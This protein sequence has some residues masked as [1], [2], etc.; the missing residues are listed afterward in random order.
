M[1]YCW[2]WVLWITRL[3]NWSLWS[4]KFGTLKVE[5]V[6]TLAHPMVMMLWWWWS[7][8]YP[9]VLM[10]ATKSYSSQ[11]ASDGQ[12]FRE[13]IRWQH[14]TKGGFSNGFFL[15]KNLFKFSLNIFR[16]H[17]L[18]TNHQEKKHCYRVGDVML[19]LDIL[20]CNYETSPILLWYIILASCCSHCL[21]LEER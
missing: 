13:L 12:K 10:V 2:S 17:N 19:K 1:G 8:F 7:F 3:A 5:E 11:S 18:A 21:I 15:T 6:T 4:D 9:L 14:V 20:L 16:Y